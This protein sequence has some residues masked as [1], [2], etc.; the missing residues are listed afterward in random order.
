MPRNGGVSFIR[1]WSPSPE[2]G[3]G[4]GIPVSFSEADN[5]VAPFL[6]GL[7]PRP[8]PPPRTG[9]GS[10][11]P[12][13]NPARGAPPVP[14]ERGPLAP[15]TLAH[16]PHRPR[17]PL[18]VYRPPREKPPKPPRGARGARRTDPTR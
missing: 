4:R 6:V 2:T 15:A 9:H 18:P 3:D 17:P 13:R 12:P 10:P 1:A 8:H 14:R 7:P 5:L 11:S 16:R